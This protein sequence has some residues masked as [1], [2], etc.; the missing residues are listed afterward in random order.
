MTSRC[1]VNLSTERY[2]PGQFRLVESLRNNTDADVLTF[3]HEYEVGAYLHSVSNYGFKPLSIEAAYKAG[4]RQIL[5]LDA[6]MNVIGDLE[7]IF[8]II[9]HDG[10]FFQD[11]GWSNARWTNYNAYR[12]FGHKDGEML[13]SG[14]LGLNFDNSTAMEF[15]TRWMKAMKDGVFNGCWSD[16]RHDQ[17]CAS[18]IAYDL[19]MKLQQA[20]TYF[21][22]GK[23]NNKF[24]V[25]KTLILADGICL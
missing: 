17:T 20:N 10:Y 2:W 11:S 4:Y 12:Y 25:D 21:V 14:V 15:F 8:Q 6:S 16:H 22:Y 1:V 13:S 5:W 7:P 24:I 19:G 9:E 18:L 23:E 3:R